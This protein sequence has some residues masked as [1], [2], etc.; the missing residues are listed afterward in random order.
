MAEVAAQPAPAHFLDHTERWLER[1][2][3]PLASVG[4][5]GML[6]AAGV[7]VADVLLRSLAGRGV[8]GLNEITSMAFGIA[9]AA[10]LPAGTAGGVHL[11]ID[12]FAR[13]ITGRLA[14]W[15]DV[16][17][18]VLLLIFFAILTHR[19]LIFSGTLYT[20]G[21]TTVLL[22][23]PM[24]PFIFVV[25]ALL[26]VSALV[27]AVIAFNK[28]RQAVAYVPVAGAKSYPVATAVAVMLAVIIV[29][30]GGYA[31]LDFSGMADWAQAN[32]GKAVA[33]AFGCM[34][35]LMLSQVPL[36]A[37]TGLIGIVAGALFIGFPPFFSAFATESAGLLTNSQIATLPLFLMMGSFAAVSGLSE[38]LY[39]LAHVLF[40]RFRGG[41]ALA[42][43]GSCAGFG[44]LTGSSLATAATIGRVAIPEMRARGYSPALATGTCAAGGTLG[45]LVPPGSGPI[46]VFAILTEASIGQLFVASVGP[47]ILAILLYFLTIMIYVRVW[48]TSAPRVVTQVEHAHL[49][50]T[51]RR[52]IPVALLVLGVMGGLYFGIFTDT[53]SAAVG[54]IGA[55]VIAIYRGKI[56]RGSYLEVMV[57]TTATTAMVYAMIIGAQAFSF[58]VL[59]SSLTES[60]T[61]FIGGLEWDKLA[62]ISII[63]LGYLLLGTVMESFA[64]MIITVPII[65]PLIV[66]IGYPV[67]WWGIVMMCV[68]ETGMIHPPFGLNVFVLKG[69][70]PNVSMWTIYRG[71]APFVVADL[72]KLVLLVLFPAITLWLPGTMHR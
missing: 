38:D 45:P 31:L 52:C 7:T 26:A 11:K 60:V 19:I 59:V 51:L 46:I 22:G 15:L 72:I 50:A 29:A 27:Q 70:T 25:V 42:T 47:A 23:L 5:L 39:E 20:Q 49:R 67:I 17:G 14:A 71:V 9:I 4:V 66:Q 69:I 54:A 10:C 32:P 3:R 24:A 62:L 18:S 63:L 68:V 48:P 64:M 6:T 8:L 57:E 55:F 28:L 41:L 56:N 16:F 2:V 33:I 36:A 30:L 21:R 37:V 53:E 61:A 12:I 13:W 44:A 34:W 35:I 58:F 43:I 40:G 1:S 65:T